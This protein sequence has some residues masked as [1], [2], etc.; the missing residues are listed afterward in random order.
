[1]MKEYEIARDIFKEN[2]YE[3]DRDYE[4]DVIGI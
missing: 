3:L 1:M 4:L 2:G